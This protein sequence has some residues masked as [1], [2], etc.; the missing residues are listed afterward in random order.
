MCAEKAALGG[1]KPDRK[2]TK[3][4]NESPTNETAEGQDN[5]DN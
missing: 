4:A 2:Q 1:K 5:P 3:K